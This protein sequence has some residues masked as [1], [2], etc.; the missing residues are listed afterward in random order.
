MA[1]VK[2]PKRHAS[3]IKAQRQSERRYS[4]NRLN[5]KNVRLAVRAVLDAVAKKDSGKIPDLM[6]KASSA[7]SKAAQRGVI[8]WKTA[9]R[10]KSRL[11]QRAAKVAAASAA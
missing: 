6:A 7:L 3:A 2:K 4:R 10:K 1:Q 11:A 8:H 9:A 5:K